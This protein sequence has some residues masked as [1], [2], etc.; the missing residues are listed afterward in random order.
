MSE[1][2]NANVF[3]RDTREIREVLS[4]WPK[5]IHI[6]L[7]TKEEYYVEIWDST[8]LRRSLDPIFYG[9]LAEAGYL[10]GLGNYVSS[11]GEFEGEWTRAPIE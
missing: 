7:I 10:L 1:I 4:S 5:A 3:D 11:T 8:N 6:E 9:M 2:R